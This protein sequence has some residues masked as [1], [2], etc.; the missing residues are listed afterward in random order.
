MAF[1]SVILLCTLESQRLPMSRQNFC[2]FHLRILPFHFQLKFQGNSKLQDQMKFKLRIII[3]RRSKGRFIIWLRH[4]VDFREVAFS[5]RRSIRLN[6]DPTQL[7]HDGQ[8]VEEAVR[9]RSLSARYEILA[10][11]SLPQNFVIAATPLITRHCSRNNTSNQRH[12]CYC[13]VSIRYT[14][15]E[16]EV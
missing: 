2:N 4:V 13:Y 11:E 8:V 10:L 7:K 15:V 9:L 16:N 5:K 6:F 3:R 14:V 1:Y 12:R